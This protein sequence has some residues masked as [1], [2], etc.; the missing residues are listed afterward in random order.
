MQAPDRQPFTNMRFRIEVEG[1]ERTGAVE[2]ILPDARIVIGPRK[3]LTTQYG[4]L[5]L[6]RGLTQASE[7]YEW[8]NRA[9]ASTRAVERAVLVVLLNER[10]SDAIRWTY[11]AATPVGYCVSHLNALGNEPLIESL[12]LR[13]GGFEASFAEPRA[14]R[15]RR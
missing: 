15:K 14:A 8:W 11:T 2:A 7:W 13:V 4:T 6:R 10:G 9:R 12:E 1:M 3:R 5:T